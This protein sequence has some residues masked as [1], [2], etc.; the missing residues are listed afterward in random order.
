MR[1]TD[2]LEIIFTDRDKFVADVTIR[3]PSLISER[4]MPAYIREIV[5]ALAEALKSDPNTNITDV[6]TVGMYV[7]IRLSDAYL[8]G[9]LQTILFLGD[10]FGRVD[11]HRG[12]TAIV[13]Y[14]SPN[15]AKLLHAGHIRSTILGHV[16]ANLLDAVGYTVHRVSY[17]NDW[18]GMGAIIAGYRRWHDQIGHAHPEYTK[19]RVL[20]EVYG[21][22]RTGEKLAGSDLFFTKSDTKLM[23][24]Y[25]R[26]EENNF[27]SFCQKFQ[28]FKKESV[29]TFA[30]LEK[31]EDAE[32][33]NLW[34]QIIVWSLGDFR[35]F[36]GLLNIPTLYQDE[37]VEDVH[38]VRQCLLSFGESPQGQVGVDIVHE[39]ARQSKIILFN[40]ESIRKAHDA[41]KQDLDAQKITEKQYTKIR[42]EIDRDRDSYVVPLAHHERY[43]I[44]KGSEAT[45][46]A[47]RDIGTLKYRIDTYHPSKIVYEVGQEQA[48]HFN[49][50][51]ETGQTLGIVPEGV[52][53]THVYHGFY[54][55]SAGKKLSSRDGASDIV[56]LI[57]YAIAY[58]RAKY[59][60]NNDFTDAEKDFAARALAVGS[61]IYNDIKKDKKSSVTIGKDFEATIKGFEE[62]G[63][64]Y[65]VYTSCRAKSILR[66]YGQS[67]PSI[68]SFGVTT[69]DPREVA[70]IKK[71]HEYP[72]TVVAAA[73]AYSPTIVAEY[74]FK[75]AQMYNSYYAVA[76]VLGSEETLYR[77]ALTQAVAQVLD[78]GLR[79]CHITPLDRI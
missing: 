37:S 74:L 49:K 69:L 64:A 9:T 8:F 29:E 68:V 5:P 44:L 22:Y 1:K 67:V 56:S 65:I 34:E 12:E 3:I 79:L 53:L 21:I 31:G 23:S 70:I 16:I 14:S 39:Y 72:T 58:F 13:D 78:N 77:L 73:D 18:G 42:E 63:G 4:G 41:L 17:I 30:T 62:S 10:D 66:K 54:V 61:I 40:D 26:A 35:T 24:E 47:T 75:L 33:V 60:N 57:E 71:L 76:P 59:D 48:D 28:L 7:N 25:F 45:I 6:T 32:T 19:N 52:E 27:E 51:F 38:D 43:V 50:L 2:N 11:T 55:D 36:Y 20:A 46:Y 15:I